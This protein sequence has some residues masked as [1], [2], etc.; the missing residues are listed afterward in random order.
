MPS[1]AGP[2]KRSAEVA[3]G[4]TVDFT[5]RVLPESAGTTRLAGG[6]REGQAANLDLTFPGG[7]DFNLCGLHLLKAG[8]SRHSIGQI[9]GVTDRFK[10]NLDSSPLTEVTIENSSKGEILIQVRPVQS[11][12]RQFDF[13][14]LLRSPLSEPRV[15][16]RIESNDRT[17]VHSHNDF[18]S[19]E[20][21]R[22]RAI[23]QGT[24]GFHANP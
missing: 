2:T 21:R 16:R 22:I 8:P 5:I 10:G 4:W 1:K 6:K 9:M 13:P 17:A 18:P 14:K 3:A 23:G 20:F 12:R 15:E 7:V 24:G 11:K 19:F